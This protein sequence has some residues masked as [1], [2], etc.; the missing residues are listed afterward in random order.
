MLVLVCHHSGPG[1]GRLRAKLAAAAKMGEMRVWGL[2]ARG[3]RVGRIWISPPAGSAVGDERT[4]ISARCSRGGD[5]S[6]DERGVGGFHAMPEERCRTR[7]YA[8][9]K[10][11][12]LSTTHPAC[13]RETCTAVDVPS[14][15]SIDEMQDGLKK[16]GALAA[17]RPFPMRIS[18]PYRDCRGAAAAGQRPRA[19]HVRSRRRGRRPHTPHAARRTPQGF[20]TVGL[21]AATLFLH[22]W[23]V[24]KDG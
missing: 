21:V 24:A 23:W 10:R 17:A 2:R 20:V 4:A 6:T 8:G 15:P 18:G 22:G 16:D 11:H 1:C 5:R 9:R 13:R 12:L 19:R 14:I 3:L 7:R